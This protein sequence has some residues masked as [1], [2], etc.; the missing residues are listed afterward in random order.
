MV[1]I[2]DLL[3]GRGSATLT[4]PRP[5][6]GPSVEFLKTRLDKLSQIHYFYACT[7]TLSTKYKVRSRFLS[8]LPPDKQIT[9]MKQH[10][11]KIFNEMVYIGFLE[12]TK[13][14]VVHCHLIVGHPTIHIEN[15]VVKASILAQL[16]E[17]GKI[18]YIDKITDDNK[19]FEY[20][21]KDY[22]P[23][24]NNY[25]CSSHFDC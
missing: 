14:G 24:L 22:D 7:Q 12:F 5:Q 18:Q 21:T 25:I 19:Y 9:F 8:R 20:I 3:N 10:L 13:Q 2:M 15:S 1:S 17:L 16:R 4:E 11:R 6:N 23:S